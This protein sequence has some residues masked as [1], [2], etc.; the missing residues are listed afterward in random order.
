MEKTCDKKRPQEKGLSSD[1][2]E[3]LHIPFGSREAG[4]IIGS[5]HVKCS[6]KLITAS[7]VSWMTSR[8]GQPLPAETS[9]GCF[10][11][12]TLIIAPP[13]PGV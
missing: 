12:M 1:M 8:A 3:D 5:T 13:F 11:S 10:V 4:R 2:T 7:C 6:T 9:Y